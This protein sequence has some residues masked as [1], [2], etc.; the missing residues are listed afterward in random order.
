MT[1]CTRACWCFPPRQGSG[2]CY[3]SYLVSM[4]IG[5][6]GVNHGVELCSGLLEHSARCIAIT[7]R[8][9]GRKTDIQVLHGNG[10]NIAAESGCVSR[11]ASG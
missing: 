4:L 10:M 2:T 9:L 11:G 6:L 7:D 8:K 5:E 1:L 3:L